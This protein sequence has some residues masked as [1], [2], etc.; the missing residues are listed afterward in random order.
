MP[1]LHKLLP[2]LSGETPESFQGKQVSPT[3]YQ[4]TADAYADEGPK[5]ADTHREAGYICNNI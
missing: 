2:K 5:D 1:P 4:V 3:L